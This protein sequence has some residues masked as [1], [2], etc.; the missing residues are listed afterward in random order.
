MVDTL[1]NNHLIKQ[2]A[3]VNAAISVLQH[4]GIHAVDSPQALERT[5][6]PLSKHVA[7]TS[8]VS[9]THIHQ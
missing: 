1:N 7:L 9:L 4:A 8:K 5:R 3:Q 2:P 6:H